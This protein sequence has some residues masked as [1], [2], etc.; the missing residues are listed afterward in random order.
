MPAFTSIPHFSSNANHGD[1]QCRTFPNK[2]AN[3]C[4]N[5]MIS[6]CYSIIKVK[7]SIFQKKWG[8]FLKTSSTKAQKVSIETIGPVLSTNKPRWIHQRA[9]DKLIF[10]S[11]NVQSRK[12][13]ESPGT[14]EIDK[15]RRIRD[16]NRYSAGSMQCNES[17]IWD[18]IVPETS[19]PGI[20]DLTTRHAI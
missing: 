10:D 13:G 7:Q 20:A 4:K 11:C 12:N 9:S 18:I 15:G 14:R 1:L 3:Y 19:R 17:L 5:V 6:I 8:N 16:V 2:I